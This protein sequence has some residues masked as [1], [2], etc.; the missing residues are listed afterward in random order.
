MKA[1]ELLKDVW[2]TDM[3]KQKRE[4]EAQAEWEEFL[5]PKKYDALFDF[6]KKLFKTSTER[7]WEEM[8]PYEKQ[9]NAFM[10]NR[11]MSI[12]YPTSAN[13]L[14]TVKTDGYAVVETW[15]Y[16][17][18]KAYSGDRVPSWMYTKTSKKESDKTLSKFKKETI[19]H[20]CQKHE[21]GVR[22]L[23]EQYAFNPSIV[24]DLNYIEK[25]IIGNDN[26]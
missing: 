18:G 6:I 15:R 8:T 23:R 16:F 5:T 9:R 10:I 22:E 2:K 20:Y 19:L 11:F 3:E 4:E 24:D 7:E 14:N 17:V 26:E 25:N 1:E 13:N 21:C 12:M